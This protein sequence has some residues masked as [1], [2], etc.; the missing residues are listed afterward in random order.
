MNVPSRVTACMAR[1]VGA[2]TLLLS[3]F[4][5]VLLAQ[6]PGG[7][8]VGVVESTDI[9]DMCACVVILSAMRCL[10]VVFLRIIALLLFFPLHS[11][12]IVVL[13]VGEAT[14]SKSQLVYILW[15]VWSIFSGSI[16]YD[17]CWLCL[18]FRLLFGPHY[19]RSNHHILLVHS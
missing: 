14:D 18:I 7:T 9:S 16:L 10:V 15:F 4:W 6:T 3:S 1:L 13:F 17:W 5:L 2:T 12:N 19:F 8:G 11:G